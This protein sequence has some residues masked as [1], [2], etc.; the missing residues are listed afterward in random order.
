MRT[1]TDLIIIIHGKTSCRVSTDNYCL[2]DKESWCHHCVNTR[3]T[4]PCF[5][6]RILAKGKARLFWDLVGKKGLDSEK[7]LHTGIKLCVYENSSH[8]AEITTLSINYSATIRQYLRFNVRQILRLVKILSNAGF[9][10]L[11]FFCKHPDKP[12][13]WPQPRPPQN[14]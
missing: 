8:F 12:I 7:K 6:N 1:P 13:R 5:L 2:H 10:S 3:L 9:F 11:I 14:A 4:R